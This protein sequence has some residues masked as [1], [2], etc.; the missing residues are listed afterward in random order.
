MDFY[1]YEQFVTRINNENKENFLKYLLLNYQ[2]EIETKKK[3]Y[4]V[5]RPQENGIELIIETTK[6]KKGQLDLN[7]VFFHHY[8]NQKWDF[9]IVTSL[10]PFDN[11]YVVKRTNNTGS[12]IIRIVN[13]DIVEKNLKPNT[14]IEG[15]VC[16]IIMIADMFE[17]ESE[18]RESIPF[19]E[20]GNKT[21]M[22]DGYII[23]F[24]L[25]NNSNAKL[26]EEERNAKDHRRDNLLTFK[27]KLKNV[28]SKEISMFNIEIPDYY[29]ATIDTT[30]GELDIIIPRPIVNRY[31]KKIKDGTII[32]GE[33]LL[34]CKLST[35]K[36][37]KKN[38][39]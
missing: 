23:P 33:L 9:K 11:T 3:K 29:T 21:V 15:Q 22:N 34:S 20:D 37:T 2:E 18:Y 6:A 17:N 10:P 32:I 39:K 7:K 5:Y 4:L 38:K 8:S 24:N 31:K 13:E 36:E 28:K 27:S 26:T 12:S 19:K 25:L 35:K 1:L 30:Y 16:G 14:T